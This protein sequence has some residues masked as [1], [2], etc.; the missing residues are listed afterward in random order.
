MPRLSKDD[1]I[2]IRELR[3]HKGY[4]SY[5]L[6]QEFPGKNW[7]R[8]TIDRWIKRI[9]QSRSIECIARSG[10]PRTASSEETVAAVEELIL[11]QEE[12][13]GTHKSTRQIAGE[14]GISHMSVFRIA[15]R[16]LHLKCLKRKR[17]QELTDANKIT[18]LSRTKQLLR[19]YPQHTVPFIWFT[20]EKIFT[21]EAPR[22]AQNDRLYVTRQTKKTQVP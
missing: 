21:V 12:A 13:P 19:R 14:I 3:I 5:R 15:H 20:D 1:K 8:R 2:L 4:N 9:D 18:R 16:N 7:C 11:S 22:N 10:R 17:A 6:L